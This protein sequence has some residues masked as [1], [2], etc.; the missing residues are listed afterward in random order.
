MKS[1]EQRGGILDSDVKVDS[2]RDSVSYIPGLSERL[3]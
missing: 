1:E 3:L 2:C